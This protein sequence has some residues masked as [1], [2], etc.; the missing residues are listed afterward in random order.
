M[1][2]CLL[3][4]ALG[5]YFTTGIAIDAQTANNNKIYACYQKND[6]APVPSGTIGFQPPPP[7]TP[8]TNEQPDGQLR[9][10]EGPGQCKQSEVEIS[11]NITGPQGNSGP[12]GPQGPRGLTGPTGPQGPPGTGLS[13]HHKELRFTLGTTESRTFSL[14]KNDVPVRIDVSTSNVPVIFQGSQINIG[15]LVGSVTFSFDSGAGIANCTVG[16]T[17]RYEFPHN[18]RSSVN[19]SGN[20]SLIL[21]LDRRTG[22]VTVAVEQG[23]DFLITVSEINYTVSMWY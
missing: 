23:I 14:P 20:L 3:L 8:N 22:N 13:D 15:P 12:M 19:Y 7:G 1:R 21:T 6:I 4:A 11:W 2:R 10:V 17:C 9:K 18:P 5:L 16:N